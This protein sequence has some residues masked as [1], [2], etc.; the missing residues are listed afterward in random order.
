MTRETPE[1]LAM[2]KAARAASKLRRYYGPWA[3]L[4]QVGLEHRAAR[5]ADPSS[6][7][8]VNM[9]TKSI[10]AQATSA[11]LISQREFFGRLLL[12]TKRTASGDGPFPLAFASRA[13]GRVE[14]GMRDG[15]T[16]FKTVSRKPIRNFDGPRVGLIDRSLAR[17]IL[18]DFHGELRAAKVKVGGKKI[19]L[20]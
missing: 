1:Y 12:A 15:S 16:L 13:D 2:Q 5:E 10:P 6:K 11:I 9:S 14:S 18:N 20:A 17:K 8:K 7:G 3:G 4:I 19:R